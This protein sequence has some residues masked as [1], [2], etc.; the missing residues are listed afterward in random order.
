MIKILRRRLIVYGAL[1]AI[2]LKTYLFYVVSNWLEFGLQFVWLVAFV[3]FWRAVY[4]GQSTVAGLGLRQTLDYAILA[5]ALMP[6]VERHLVQ[7]FGWMLREGQMAIEL[8]RPMDFQARTYIEQLTDLLSALLQKVPLLFFAWLLFGL[9]LPSEPVVWLAFIV[10]LLLGHAVLFCF[11]WAFACLA[12][13][14]T[15]TSGLYQSRVGIARFVS[16][17]LVP[18][19]MMPGWLRAICDGLP[20]AQ[21]IFIPVSL[22]SGIT[23]ISDVLRVW[24]IQAL[25]LLGLIV[26]SRLAFKVAIRQ[27]TVQGG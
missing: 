13:Y 15:Q 3:Y 10:S 6:L 22:L 26:F 7:E 19:V 24:S 23:P 20:F 1:A 21:A 18:L 9:R 12:F 5:T 27:V 2:S 25:W 8:L 17:A 14:T 4:A 11:D 16:G